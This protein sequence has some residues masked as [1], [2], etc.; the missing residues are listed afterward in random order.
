MLIVQH[1]EGTSSL[2]KQ[3]LD[4][5]NIKGKSGPSIWHAKQNELINIHERRVSLIFTS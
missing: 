1:F 3:G 4:R 5:S 2:T